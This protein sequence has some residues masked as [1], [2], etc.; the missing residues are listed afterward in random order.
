MTGSMIVIRVV[1]MVVMAIPLWFFLV[2]VIA[3]VCHGET[4]NSVVCCVFNTL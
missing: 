4:P 3:T 1:R 2:I